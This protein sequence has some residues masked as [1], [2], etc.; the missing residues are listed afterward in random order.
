MLLHGWEYSLAGLVVLAG[1]F[2]HP[3]LLAA[4]LA[5][6]AHVIADQLHNG[7]SPPGYSIIYR[8]VKRFNASEIAPQHNVATAYWHVLGILPGGQRLAPWF[9]KRVGQEHVSKIEAP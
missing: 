6:L 5:H 3:L 7:V 9:Q 2:Y 4:V 1:V 8:A